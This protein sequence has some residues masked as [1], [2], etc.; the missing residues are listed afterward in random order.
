MALLL[1]DLSDRVTLLS[2]YGLTTA[3]ILYRLPDHPSILQSYVWQDYDVTPS[4]P[5]LNKF[6][7]FWRD[8]L[9][10]ALHAVRVNH[11]HLLKPCELRL[12]GAEFQLH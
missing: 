9:D 11:A 8:T 10:G 3:E 5:A 12:I 1:D 6:L 4:F 7:S 2:G